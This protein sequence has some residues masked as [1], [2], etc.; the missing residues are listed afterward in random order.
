MRDACTRVHED[1]PNR[2]KLGQ[3]RS[4]GLSSLESLFLVLSNL[5]TILCLVAANTNRIVCME[6]LPRGTET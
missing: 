1:S 2:K 6:S 3:N 4:D 5:G